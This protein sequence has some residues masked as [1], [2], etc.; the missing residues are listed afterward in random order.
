MGDTLAPSLRDTGSIP[1]PGSSGDS[2]KELLEE[3]YATLAT[4][5]DGNKLQITDK[6]AVLL[7]RL[8]EE[9]RA[10]VSSIGRPRGGAAGAVTR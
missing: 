1:A 6:G 3:R 7:R 9:H 8:E 10:V 5:G 2:R 4:G